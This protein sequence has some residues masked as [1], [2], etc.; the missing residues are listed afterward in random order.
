MEA[1]K[2][3]PEMKDLAPFVGTFQC[4]GK[5]ARRRRTATTRSATTPV[6]KS[7]SPA[8]T[9]ILASIVRSIFKKDGKSL[10]HTGDIQMNGKWVTL[11]E[12]TCKK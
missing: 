5:R 4:A 11:I 12:E 6:K 9:I 8:G 3:A 7:S 10:V 1:P 2:P